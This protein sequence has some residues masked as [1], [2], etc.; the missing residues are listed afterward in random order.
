MRGRILTTLAIV[1]FALSPFLVS[2]Q[3]MSIAQ[4]VFLSASPQNPAP[5]E[6]VTMSVS[7]SEINIDLSMVDWSVDGKS[8]KKGMGQK[9]FSFTA[10][11]NGKSTTVTVRVTPNGGSGVEETMTFSPAD[12]DIIWEAEGAYVP[13]FY[14]G[15]TLPI[16]QGGVKIVAMPNVRTSTGSMQK[17][18]DFAF[19]WKKDGQNMPGN[20]G[21]GKQSFTYINQ[22][23]E[24][25][26]RIDVSAATG[27]K[28]VEGGV[29]ISY[30]EPKLLMYESDALIGTKYQAAIPSMY[31]SKG[32]QLALILEPYFLPRSWKTD[33][34][35]TVSWKLNGQ[36]VNAKDRQSFSVN[37]SG[38]KGAFTLTATYNEAKKLFRTF[39]KS[40]TVT[41]I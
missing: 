19:S 32:A 9:T 5:G 3:S 17:P 37:T 29:I 2:A 33:S 21:F 7:S 4:R 34:G 36:D 18:S 11:G 30:F 24:D 20:S 26:N 23:L 10:P 40:I 6:T 16:K 22:M 27:T 39:S 15:K 35:T 25:T 8:I 13:P 28:R 41:P 1:L 12:I 31:R 38:E 14:K